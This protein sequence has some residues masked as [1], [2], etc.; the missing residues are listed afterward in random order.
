MI[1]EYF[2][3]SEDTSSTPTVDHDVMSFHPVCL[4]LN[5]VQD[6]Y[7]A[8]SVLMEYTCSG[9]T[10]EQIVSECGNGE[11]CIVY[12]W[13]PQNLLALKTTEANF[14]TST[15]EDCAFCVSFELGDLIFLFS[16]ALFMIIP[17]W[18]YS[19]THCVGTCA[20]FIITGS[21]LLLLQH[22]FPQPV[23]HLAVKVSW[24]ALEEVLT[25]AVITVAY[26]CLSLY[27]LL[28]Y[29]AYFTENNH[30]ISRMCNTYTMAKV[31]GTILHSWKLKMFSYRK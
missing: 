10:M 4:A 7:H 19:V 18:D 31:A 14:S 27:S 22:I 30:D 20:L 6:H 23:T 25:S 8:V 9:H 5:D 15:T 12:S 24:D 2:K 17:G 29:V 26:V 16:L 1:I 21:C 3:V 11:C 28:K 13:V